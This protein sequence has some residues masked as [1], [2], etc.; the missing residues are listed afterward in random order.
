MK[1]AQII[2]SPTGGTQRVA[3]LLCAQWGGDIRRIDLSNA[4][5]D[6]DSVR[7]EPEVKIIG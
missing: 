3:D 6:F 7:L 2:F 5:F 4:H 1:I